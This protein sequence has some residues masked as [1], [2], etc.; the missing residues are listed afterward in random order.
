[1]VNRSKANSQNSWR[2]WREFGAVGDRYGRVAGEAYAFFD[3]N[4]SG[5]QIGQELPT[6]RELVKTPK[7]LVLRLSEEGLPYL[8]PNTFDDELLNI[9]SDAQEAGMRY[10]LAARGLPTMT[11]RQT[12]DELAAILNQAYQSPLYEDGETFRGRVFYKDGERYED[13]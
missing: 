7:G 12:A 4:A 10:S 6:I 11:N 3:C 8:G 13:R 1:M 2:K 9:Y 5:E